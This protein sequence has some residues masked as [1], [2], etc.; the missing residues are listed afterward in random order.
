MQA[1]AA[2]AAQSPAELKVGAGTCGLAASS[3]RQQCSN[4]ESFAMDQRPR[5]LPPRTDWER[6]GMRDDGSW[7]VLP[8]LLVVAV[9]AIGAWLLFADSAKTP[10]TTT[11]QSTPVTAPSG[12]ATTPA[13]TPTTPPANTP[14]PSAA[15]SPPATKP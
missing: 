14:S 12:P 10:T 11:S 15:P 1:K 3:P 8:I 2:A 4:P 13:P 9:L 5:D 7:S 6:A